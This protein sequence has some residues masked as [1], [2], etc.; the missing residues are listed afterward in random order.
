M[1]QPHIT[2]TCLYY[3]TSSFMAVDLHNLV[4]INPSRA[5]SI[6]FV[7]LYQL[8]ALLFLKSNLIFMAQIIL[9]SVHPLMKET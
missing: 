7:C 8:L 2:C 4:F 6:C 5:V 9:E 1:S 3:V